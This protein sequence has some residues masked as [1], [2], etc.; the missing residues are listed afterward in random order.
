M[1]VSFLFE[2]SQA[3]RGHPSLG[4]R[5]VYF[6]TSCKASLLSQDFITVSSPSTFWTLWL[7]CCQP[8]GF[9]SARATSPCQHASLTFNH[10]SRAAF[11]SYPVSR[12]L[13]KA[14]AILTTLQGNSRMTMTDR[15]LL[16]ECLLPIKWQSL[17]GQG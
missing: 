12:L 2:G 4:L 3:L 9:A 17:P 8:S 15:L 11:P 5:F 10:H 7:L 1:L 6:W 14:S 13:P 16:I